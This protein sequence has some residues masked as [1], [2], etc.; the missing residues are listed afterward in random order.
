VQ[1]KIWPIFL[2]LLIGAP[3]CSRK[4]TPVNPPPEFDGVR[5]RLACPKNQE[6][7]LREYALP[8]ARVQGARIETVPYDPPFPAESPDADIWVLLPAELPRWAEAGQLHPVPEALTRTGNPYRWRGLLPYFRE[9]LVLW[10]RSPYALPLLGESP[11]CCVRTDRFDQEA[12]RNA[13][14]EKFGRQPAAPRTWE[15]FADLA[16]FFAGQPGGSPSLPPLPADDEGLTRLFFQ[17][18]VSYARRAVPLDED[19]NQERFASAFSL[20][21]DLK[22][23]EP[24]IATPPFVHALALLR[25][26]Q[27]FRPAE[28][29]AEPE[30]A[31]RTGQAVLCLTDSSH[32]PD[33]QTASGVRDRFDI[34]PVP[35]TTGYFDYQ[36]EQEVTVAEGNRI[37]FLGAGPWLGCVPASTDKAAAAFA[38]LAHLSGPET[39]RQL[40][41]DPQSGGPVRQQQLTRDRW[42][43]FRLDA[44]RTADLRRTVQ[45]TLAHRGL[46]NPAFV[47]R[48]P[49]QAAR[50][51]VLAEQLREALLRGKDPDQALQAVAR[52]WKELDAKL[53]PDKQRAWYR[54][55]I[56]LLPR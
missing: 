36:T 12:F 43:A 28:P 15:E 25:R 50:Q 3:G 32:L 48:M 40:A 27:A 53:G 13:F 24:R 6:S 55:S 34:V 37:P 1:P 4:K 23:G 26:L 45:E 11:L 42:D 16:A 2:I 22:T 14:R 18:A 21:Y 19:L 49:D 7:L 9:R 8:W 20:Y 51:K 56:G 41:S 54:L 39:A 35:G 29:A 33:F 46:Q 52:A 5:L 38:L 47:L 31:F 30:A 17:V 44:R 10:D